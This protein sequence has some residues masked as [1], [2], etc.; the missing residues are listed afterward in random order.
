MSIISIVSV[1]GVAIGVAVLCIV[2]S[3]MGGFEHE[4]RSKVLGANSHILVRSIS[5]ALLDW[6]ERIK[7]INAVPG[8]ESVAPYAYAQALIRTERAAS[9]VLVRGIRSDDAAAKQVASYLPKDTSVQELLGQQK[10]DSGSDLP[11]IIIG[12]ELSRTLSLYPGSLVTLLSPA[13][14]SSPFGLIPRTKRFVVSAV[15]RSG[16]S[17][18][19]ATVAYA[20]LK[21]TQAFFQLGNGVTGLEVRVKNLQRAKEISQNIF[22]GLGGANSGLFVQPWS[23]T[24]QQLWEAIQLEKRVYFLVLLLIIIMASFSIIT[25]LVMIVIEKRRDIATLMMMG[26]SP[27]FVSKVFRTQGAIIGL[28]GVLLGLLLGVT[29]CWALK[30]YGF[31]LNEKV[32]QMSTVPVR[33]EPLSFAVVGIVAFIICYAAT[34]YP[35][36]RASRIR[37]A[38]LLRS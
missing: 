27:S 4:L 6:E 24:N 10:G 26:A 19:E 20:A 3:V 37:P 15:Y 28:S 8:V 11:P 36:W 25:T 5:G 38:E 18:Y 35:A 30:A 34:L 12:A 17:E 16:L 22:S 9:G 32:F 31:P 14:S 1:L 23:E 29:G 13:V 21:D 7:A 2:M 33:A